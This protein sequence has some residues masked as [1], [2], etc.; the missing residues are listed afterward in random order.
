MVGWRQ[1][2]PHPAIAAWA[3]AALPL[4]VAAL[5]ATDEPLRCGGTWAVGLDLLPND[6]TG[7]IG[8]VDL[9]WADPGLVARTD[10]RHVGH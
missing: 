9:P 10:P 2:G 7:R 4:A 8:G 6:D 3:K 1:I 5:Q